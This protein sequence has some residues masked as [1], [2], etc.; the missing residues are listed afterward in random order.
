MFEDKTVYLERKVLFIDY[1]S[2][3]AVSFV[4]LLEVTGMSLFINK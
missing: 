3:L 2:F 1:Y 4:A